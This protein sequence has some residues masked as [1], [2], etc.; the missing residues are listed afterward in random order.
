[1]GDPS[2]SEQHTGWTPLI[3][4]SL[5]N[6]SRSH[7]Q[8]TSNNELMDGINSNDHS[9]DI[10]KSHVSGL[11]YQHLMMNQFSSPSKMDS[12]NLERILAI[13][14]EFLDSTNSNFPLLLSTT[15]ISARNGNYLLQDIFMDTPNLSSPNTAN[16]HNNSNML[17]SPTKLMQQSMLLTAQKKMTPYK[18]NLLSQQFVYPDTPGTK[19]VKSLLD[20]PVTATPLPPPTLPKVNRG[21]PLK[22]SATP[23][24]KKARKSTKR[25]AQSYETPKKKA[26]TDLKTPQK[27]VGQTGS[28]PS[29]IKVATISPATKLK[30]KKSNGQFSPTPSSQ[31]SSN[32]ST[33]SLSSNEIPNLQPPP[34][35]TFK[36]EEK[37][38]QIQPPTLSILSKANNNGKNGKFQIIFQD[39]DSLMKKSLLKSKKNRS[40]S[41]I[42]TSN[43]NKR[44][45]LTRSL[46]FSGVAPNP[47]LFNRSMSSMSLDKENQVIY[48]KS[49]TK[50][51]Q[52]YSSNDPS[53]RDSI[54]SQIKR[55]LDEHIE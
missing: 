34:I 20:L 24:T 16:L 33:Q 7:P 29:T 21:S 54:L 47:P 12:S 55:G 51:S 3:K 31:K 19:F 50:Q 46:T 41:G 30:N 53:M 2:N 26:K 1:M 43:N 36:K 5:S 14:N 10:Y 15:P 48:D 28:S 42:L 25:K 49:R 37:Q 52:Q 40:K 18:L 8:H 11:Q 9:A 27:N 4:Q 17:E 35:G 45:Q 23:L 44:N 22:E 39:V 38:S 13:E 6:H 32:N